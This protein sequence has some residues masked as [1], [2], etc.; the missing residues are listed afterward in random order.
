M[1]YLRLLI[2]YFVT[3]LAAL[4][5]NFALPRLAPGDPLDYLLGEDSLATMSKAERL[6]LLSDFG[7]DR[8]LTAQ[9]QQ[10]LLGL[11]HGDFGLSSQLGQPVWDILIER[12][13]WTL[14]LTTGALLFATLA[15]IVLGLISV[16]KHD[17]VTDISILGTTLFFSSLPP[18]W[19][20]MVLIIVFSTILQWL[21]SFGAYEVG[22]VT[23]SWEW[24]IGV[25]K[26]LIM[27]VFALGL[28]QAGA[29][30]LLTRASMLMVL[31]EDYIHFARSRGLSKSRILLR[32]AFRNALLPIYTNGMLGIGS[33]IG[34]AL[35]VETVFSYPGL[36]SLI[37]NAVIAKDYNM[38]QGLFVIT[39]LCVIAANLATDLCYPLIDP[40][41]R[42]TG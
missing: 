28:V 32:H 1:Y 4:T 35:V 11:F 9:F 19:L 5:I 31:N 30:L 6:Q 3:L 17:T 15:G 2:Q 25:G 12:L 18:F 37:V 38:L 22:T 13:P 27:P 34:G 20:A 7:L 40:R 8:P 33:L 23:G 24:Y 26:R 39:T 14:L 21:P 10:Y 36:G 41:T 16:W 42:K 29:I